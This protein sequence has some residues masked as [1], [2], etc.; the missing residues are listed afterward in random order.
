MFQLRLHCQRF[1]AAFCVALL[2]QLC[3][4]YGQTSTL[5]PGTEGASDTP[6]VQIHPSSPN[7]PVANTALSQAEDKLSSADYA[8][9]RALLLPYI[10]AHPSD[11]RALFDLGYSEDASG[12]TDQAAADY[13]KSIA[14]DPRQFESH[15]ALGLL[16]ANQGDTKSA[17]QELQAASK[18]TPVPPNPV[19]QGQA[20]RTLARLLEPTD[21]A[22]ARLALID[23]LRESPT[24]A[25]DSLLAADIAAKAGDADTAADAYGKVL[26]DA[27]AGSPERAQAASGLAHLLIAAK[28]YPEAEAVLHKA[29]ASDPDNLPLNAELAEVLSAEGKVPEAL[30][31]V[32]KLHTENP[33]DGTVLPVLA[34]L[35]SQI[36]DTAKALPLYQQLLLAH[37]HDPALLAE[38]GDA[39]VRTGNYAP[40]VPVLQEATRLD[41]SSGNTWSSLAFAA[42]QTKQPQLVL[43]ALAMRS[44]VMSETP[45]TYFLEATACDSLHLTKRA[46]TLYRQFLTVAG[47]GFPDEEWQAK[48]RLV[49][50]AK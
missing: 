5:P 39:M 2:L 32:E 16:L 35:Y 37:P 30:A 23:A 1:A 24:T 3:A 7:A 13:R 6:A 38:V 44:K 42:N 41:P 19:A 46:V 49:A 45:A 34:D 29:L 50:L 12:S 48:H 17:V 26:V 22:A 10:S 40:A 25:A 33:A 36:G 18:L 11:P 20:N 43:D 15:M 14:A 9:A 28:R 4:A 27:P 47:T 21:P 8:G 31:L